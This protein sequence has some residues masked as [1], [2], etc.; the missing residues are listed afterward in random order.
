MKAK[1][2]Y[3][4]T[5]VEQVENKQ[6]R[7]KHQNLEVRWRRCGYWRIITFCYSEISHQNYDNGILLFFIVHDVEL[8]SRGCQ[9]TVTS[10]LGT[11]TCATEYPG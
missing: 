3:D 7:A 10:A 9:Y 2:T 11:V 1:T 4:V 6:G 5:K 8:F